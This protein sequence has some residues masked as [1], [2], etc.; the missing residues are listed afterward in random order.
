MI[1]SFT[2]DNKIINYF[3]S[4]C[5]STPT[6]SER[7]SIFHN[8]RRVGLQGRRF[9]IGRSVLDSGF[10]QHTRF[11]GLCDVSMLGRKHDIVSLFFNRRLRSHAW[12]YIRCRRNFRA[13]RSLSHFS[14]LF[15]LSSRPSHSLRSFGYRWLKFF[16][17]SGTA[18]E[19]VNSY[20]RQ[21]YFFQRQ[22]LNRS[23][24][25]VARQPAFL[26][27][28]GRLNFFRPLQRYR[29][30]NSFFNR[31]FHFNSKQIKFFQFVYRARVFRRRY[32]SALRRSFRPYPWCQTVQS[33]LSAMV[34]AKVRPVLQIHTMFDQVFIKRGMGGH[35]SRTFSFLRPWRLTFSRSSFPFFLCSG[36]VQ[37]SLSRFRRL[38]GLK[39]IYNVY[40]KKI[41]KRKRSLILASWRLR[42]FYMRCL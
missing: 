11:R 4:Y 3:L 9:E 8:K 19:G 20:R 41:I 15:F 39:G 32:M 40:F 27:F 26:F 23:E 34:A 7:V 1:G 33:T 10:I 14:S 16:K 17:V 5:S 30:P 12:Y 2:G 42:R 37:G 36:W 29:L 35:W 24:S 22:R 21:F 6:L 25:L 18:T 38:F 13:F 28:A 31:K